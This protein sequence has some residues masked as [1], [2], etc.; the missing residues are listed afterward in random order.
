[1]RAA[2]RAANQKLR[3][4]FCISAFGLRDGITTVRDVASA[5]GMLRLAEA[6]FRCSLVALDV[7][8]VNAIDRPDATKY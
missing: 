4:S 8:A 1:M 7:C 2:I 5:E 6:V 3:R